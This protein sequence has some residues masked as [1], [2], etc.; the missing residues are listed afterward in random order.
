[1]WMLEPCRELDLAIESL[2]GHAASQLR[3]QQLHHH[4]S[5]QRCLRGEVHA[6]HATATELALDDIGGSERCLELLVQ[7]VGQGSRRKAER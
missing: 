2:D 5:A 4:L 1:M 6:R 7:C 3:R